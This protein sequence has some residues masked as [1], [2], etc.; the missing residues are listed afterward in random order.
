MT[1][2][3]L[4]L[5]SAGSSWIP[6]ALE[7]LEGGHLVVLPTET[8][9]GIAARADDEKALAKLA[10]AKG[11]PNEMAWTWHVGSPLALECYSDL[12]AGIRRL[13]ERYWPGPLTLVLPGVPD[14]LEL[15]SRDGWTGIRCTAGQY[16]R[17]LCSAAPFPLVMTSAN[18]HGEIAATGPDDLEGLVLDE[19]DLLLEGES[20]NLPGASTIL[21][22]G[23]GRFDLLREGLH[24]I[25]SLRQTAGMKIGFACTGNT[26]RSPMAEGIARK[27]LAAKLGCPESEIGKFGFEVSSMGIFAGAGSPAAE[28][29][30]ATMRQRKIDISQHQ[31][32]QATL[33]SVSDLDVVYCLTASH[34]QA[35]E[36]MIPPTKCESLVLL[37]PSGAD[38]PDPIGGDDTVYR[39][40][41]DRITECI[42]ARIGEWA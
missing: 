28:H 37:D 12:G 23:A 36:Q 19:D 8:V 2:N 4:R 16:S 10:A 26:C 32:S 13:T 38:I 21:Q 31:S 17:A 6:R 33:K 15:A 5:S 40:C 1:R 7:T 11:R 29:A 35:L 30:I 9:Y 42:E 25:E 22:I 39:L 41:A 20:K 14:G 27:T 3:R 34:L 24:T 18:L